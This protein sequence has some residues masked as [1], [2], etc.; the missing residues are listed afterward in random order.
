[1]CG[2][3]LLGL[4]EVVRVVILALCSR[5]NRVLGSYFSFHDCDAITYNHSL[6]QNLEYLLLTEFEVR[7]LGH[8]PSRVRL[9]NLSGMNEI[10]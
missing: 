8:G 2:S 3:T 4:Q 7:A 9:I 1:M 6:T 10:L 5:K